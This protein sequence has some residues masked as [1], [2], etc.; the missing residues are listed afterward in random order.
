MII[1]LA[2]AASRWP[3]Y[4]GPARLTR[5]TTRVLVHAEKARST[6]R[7]T[8]SCPPS[9]P[10]GRCSGTQRYRPLQIERLRDT[11]TEKAKAG[12]EGEPVRTARGTGFEGENECRG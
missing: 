11:N 4:L 1:W 10:D 12:A 2:A 7:S 5:A 6:T 3:G 8:P 9:A